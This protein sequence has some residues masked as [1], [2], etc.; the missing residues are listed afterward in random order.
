MINFRASSV[1]NLMAY[2][3]KAELPQGALT[4]CS[5]MTSQILLDWQPDFD[6]YEM[7][8]G[9]QVEQSSIDLLNKVSGSYYVKNKLRMTTDLLTGE[10]D[11]IDDD[12]I[13]DIKS[14][15]SKKTFPIFIKE[16]DRKMY[17]WQLTAYMYLFDRP[18]ASIIYTL[19]NTPTNLIKK[20][21]NPDWHTVDRVPEKYRITEFHMTR[22]AKRENQLLNRAALAKAK[23]IELLDTRG[24]DWGL[25]DVVDTSKYH[26]LEDF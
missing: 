22:D 24:Y 6:S 18:K 15:Y 20:G 4:F 1:G 25:V 11:I 7:M 12:I 19:V 14:A 5:E 9:R 26:A 17:E 13:I 8:K 2:P 16:G 23:V 10:C 21:D 3:D